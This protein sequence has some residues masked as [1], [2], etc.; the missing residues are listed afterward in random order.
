MIS[1]CLMARQAASSADATTKSVS[2]RPWISA[3]RL[4]RAITS[5]GRRASRR[6]T[7][8]VSDFMP[9]SYGSLPYLSS[10]LQLHHHGAARP[11]FQQFGMR[12]VALVK[13]NIESLVLIQGLRTLRC[14]RRQDSRFQI[15]H[16]DVLVV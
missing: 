3:A 8:G 13:A 2:V 9:S 15:N 1:V 12:P 7:V 10:L 14:R 11:V 16:H 6:A 4:I 5:F